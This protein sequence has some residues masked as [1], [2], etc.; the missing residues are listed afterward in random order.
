MIFLQLALLMVA[1]LALSQ[2][3]QGVRM[4]GVLG[5]LLAGVLVTLLVFP[6]LP[7][8]LPG[9]D[10]ASV[11]PMLRMAVLAIVLLRVGFSLTPGDLRGAGGLAVGLG[12]VPMLGD[13]LA[14]AGTGVVLLGLPL[15]SAAVLGFL[16]AAISPAIVIPGLME[17]LE[18]RTGA[19]RRLPTALLV[20]AP[21]DNIAAVL[22]LGVALDLA[23]AGDGAWVQTL[24][25]LP[26]QTVGGVAAGAVVGGLF[27]RAVPESLGQGATGTAL[28]WALAV[29]LILFCQRVGLSPVLAVLALGF[30][31]PLWAP[32]RVASLSLG[33][34]GVWRWAQLL[35]FG[36]I[37]AAVR[38]RPLAQA[39]LSYA[40]VIL[41]GQAG[42]AGGTLLI[43]TGARLTPRERFACVLAYLPK[44][45][46]QAAFAGLPLARGLP[47]GEAIL[48]IGVL[49]IVLTAPLGTFALHKGAERLLPR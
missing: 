25:R 16:V 7:A 22:A 41:A 15:S 47:H 40:A 27:A 1:S 19:A 43:T 44:A 33:L 5:A 17:L 2:A 4:P 46:I 8:N 28:L 3:V 23:L 24:A 20:G 9:P 37:G 11:S 6:H 42:R 13:A 34:A 14:A 38:L 18:R 36:L 29:G 39:G 32:H 12:L 21:L 26:L 10:L 49:A 30:S 31:L 45:T 48:S 35:L